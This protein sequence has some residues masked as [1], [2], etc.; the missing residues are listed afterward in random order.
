MVITGVRQLQ[1]MSRGSCD[2]EDS[3]MHCALNKPYPA[4][5]SCP[6]HTF[7]RSNQDIPN[8]GVLKECIRRYRLKKTSSSSSSRGLQRCD[9]LS[10]SSTQ[11]IPGEDRVGR[12]L[13]ILNQLI[14]PAP[15]SNKVSITSNTVSDVYTFAEVPC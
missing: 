3:G 10:S 6:F 15:W 5:C 13:S 1:A 11:G 8:G 7:L 4:P 14:W 9:M 12:F 2:E